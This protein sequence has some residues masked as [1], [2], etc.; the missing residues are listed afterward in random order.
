VEE[1]KYENIDKELL[2]LVEDVMFNRNNKNNEATEAILNFAATIDPK[3]KPC[4]VKRNDDV[5]AIA[6]FVAGA[7]TR[8]LLSSI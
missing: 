1:D 6:K 3:S 4:K 2:K 5:D 8:P 7:Y